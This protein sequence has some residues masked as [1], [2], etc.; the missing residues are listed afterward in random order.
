MLTITIVIIVVCVQERAI[1]V[2]V[3][4]GCARAGYPGVCEGACAIYTQIIFMQ[5]PIYGGGGGGVTKTFLSH[6][7]FPSRFT[8]F[9]I[10]F[11]KI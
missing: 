1:L 9:L 4:G 2:G 11:W 7:M 6:F 8:H 10:N 5:P 3:P